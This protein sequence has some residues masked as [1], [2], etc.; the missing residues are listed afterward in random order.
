MAKKIIRK[1]GN[2]MG[3][4]FA[5]SR[6]ELQDMVKIRDTYNEDG[7]IDR[8]IGLAQF[9]NMQEYIDMYEALPDSH[10]AVSGK[11]ESDV[12]SKFFMGTK[13]AYGRS[14]AV[15]PLRTI[16]GIVDSAKNGYCHNVFVKQIDK[17]RDLLNAENIGA[18]QDT[19]KSIKRVTRFTDDGAEL[20]IDRVMCGDTDYWR[21]T[22]RDGQ[23]RVVRLVIN[24][25]MSYENKAEDFMKLLA[26]TYVMAELIEAKG[27]GLEIYACSKANTHSGYL[28][29]QSVLIP[30]KKAQESIDIERLGV[31]GIVGFFRHVTFIM[32]N[33]MFGYYN[34]SCY[35]T[36]DEM[37]AFMGAD[38]LVENTWTH[39]SSKGQAKR[40]TKALEKLERGC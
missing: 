39:G 9:D 1:H 6:Q 19:L 28:K 30:L 36:S 35:G 33:L 34:G 11:R 37:Q 40:I 26:M 31:V 32:C 38:V 17:Y 15:R 16:E 21:T 27:Y 20:D 29:E 24:F 7:T 22:R 5:K 13:S 12:D 18:L 10:S 14:K 4:S 23:Y 25:A 8:P 3:V 2:Y